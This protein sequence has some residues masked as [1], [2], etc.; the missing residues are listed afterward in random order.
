MIETSEF[1]EARKPAYKLLIDFCEDIGTLKSSAQIT[2]HYLA[3]ELLGKQIVVIVNFPPKQI[4][5]FMSECLVTGFYREDGVVLVS[6]DKPVPNGA[7]L[8]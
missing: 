3:E 5:P 1:P 7:K 6:P 2:E 8:G 4:G